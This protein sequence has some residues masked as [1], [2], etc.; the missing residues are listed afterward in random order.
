MKIIND[1]PHLYFLGSKEIVKNKRSCTRKGKEKN[2][3]EDGGKGKISVKG[4]KV[5]VEFE[6]PSRKKRQMCDEDNDEFVDE[7]RPSRKQKGK[8]HEVR[9]PKKEVV[10]KEKAAND[11]PSMKNRCS[12][13]ALLSIIHG[14]SKAQK[15]CVREMGLGTLLQSKLMDVPMKMCYYVL[16]RLDVEKMEVVVE[17]GVLNVNAK[18]VHEMLGLPIGGTL[19]KDMPVVDEDDE[20]SCMFEWRKQYENTKDLRLKQLKNEILLTREG[21]LNF[22]INFLVMFINTFCES[23]SMGKC[24][25]NALQHIKKDTDISSIDWCQYVV[26]CLIKTKK[27]Y[28]PEKESSFFFGPAA[29]L[30]VCFEF[31]ILFIYD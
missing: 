17:K 18:S 23:T 28:K 20:D 1:C 26:D 8:V 5:V 9:N 25:L 10:R 11:F 3:V 30:A 19:F 2:V 24:N 13:I 15:N 4:K 27:A 6:K 16:E 7:A 22:R 21:D 29:Y 14:L 12:P 31:C